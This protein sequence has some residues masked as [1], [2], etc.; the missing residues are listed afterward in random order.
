M[1]KQTMLRRVF[2][3]ASI[4]FIMMIISTSAYNFTTEIQPGIL[5]NLIVYTSAILMFLSIW[6]G[7]LFVNTLAFFRGAV[8][9]ERV[10]ASLITPAAWIIYT[11]TFFIGIFSPGELAFLMLHPFILGNIGVN[12]LCIGISELICRRRILSQGGYIPLFEKTNTAVLAAGLIITFAGLYNLG[13]TYYYY[14][15]DIYT[16]LFM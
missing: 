11:Y 5:K 14:Y 13:H 1:K 2:F 3:P 8:F 10:L 12:L 16:L 6:L 15:M 7:P 4:A 9:S